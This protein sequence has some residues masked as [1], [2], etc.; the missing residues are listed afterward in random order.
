MGRKPHADEP[1]SPGRTLTPPA[2]AG[3]TLRHVPTPPSVAPGRALRTSFLIGIACLVVYNAN[4]RSISA[5]DTYP[6]RYM[7][8]G[9]LRHGTLSLDPILTLTQQGRARTYW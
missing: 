9:I 6:A 4:L 8:F 7:P 1:G 2:G 5:G 3:I